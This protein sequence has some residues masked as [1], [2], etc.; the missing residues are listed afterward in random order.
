MNFNVSEYWNNRLGE[1]F[2][3]KGVGHISFSRFYNTWLYKTKLF[4]LNKIK[5]EKKIIL[6]QKKV[7]DIGSGTG[8]FVEYYT[9]K[10]AK[11]TGLDITDISILYLSKKYPQSKF[12]TLDISNAM[13]EEKFDIINMWDVIYHQ[14]DENLFLQTLTNISKM[15]KP[16]SFFICTDTFGGNQVKQ[17]NEHVVFR[18]MANYAGI[19]DKLGFKLIKIYPLYRWMNRPYP[20]GTRVTNIL[21]PFLFL[22]DVLNKKVEKN[23]LSVAVW[24]FQS[25]QDL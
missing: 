12:Y 2:S 6:A 8:F 4:V 13:I 3:L 19:M 14:V 22:L 15:L 25:E 9:Q 1:N 11:I 16:G 23:N 17:V 18:P 10:K 21:A 5:N 24:I 7:L 20:W